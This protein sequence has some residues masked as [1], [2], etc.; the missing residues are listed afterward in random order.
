[1]KLFIKPLLIVLSSALFLMA[2][3]D[4]NIPREG[5]QYVTLPELL[6]DK[7]LPPVS[8]VFSLT[9]SHCRNIE[10]F[11]PQISQLADTDIGKMHITFNQSADNAALLYYAAEIQ[12]GSV[13]DHAFMEE[14]FAAIQAPRNVTTEQKKQA[15]E[16]AFSSRN[17]V[18]PDQFSKQQSE[19]LTNKVDQIRRLSRQSAINAVPT[20]IVKGRYQVL[21]AGH[22]APEQIAETIKYLLNQ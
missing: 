6:E 13:P 12:L 19:Q 22:D 21:V 10:N 7:A 11:L 17:L 2:C 18:S 5:E 16:N 15:I 20:F 4:S 9:C 8:E 3:S 1:M 14:L